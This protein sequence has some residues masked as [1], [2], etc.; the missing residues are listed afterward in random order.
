VA[1]A[2]VGVV[3]FAAVLRSRVGGEL[4][5]LYVDDLGT[6]MA[7]LAASVLWA[8]AGTRRSG[9]QRRFC[10]LLTA[11]CASWTLGEVI[12]AVYDLALRTA[13]PVPSWADLGYL[14]AI[15]F[16][17]AAL[18]SHPALAGDARRR[19]RFTLDGL[20]VAT[21][22]L[23]LSWTVVLGPL[24]H[25]TDLSTFGG[26]VTIAYPFSDVVVV[27]FVV[28]AVRRLPSE[29]RV[30]LWC[31]L[32]GLLALA[33]SDSIYAYQ[34]QAQDYQ[35]TGLLDTGWFAG[36]L[37][38]ALGAVSWQ[39]GQIATRA[40]DASP[41]FAALVVPFVPILAALV[42]IGLKPELVQQLDPV[43]LVI[44]FALVALVLL[45]QLLVVHDIVAAIGDYEGTLAARL[46]AVLGA[47]AADETEPLPRPSTR[48]AA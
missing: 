29:N 2:V 43:A 11:A 26:L 15:P 13:V 3:L 22:L 5:V 32:A 9:A 39:R 17:L 6:V 41:R 48:R 35:T 19:A 30:P 28:L 34:S 16:A 24:W 20:L 31:L 10:W 47:P 27:F 25:S 23:C 1:I 21:A 18:L 44:A 38:I 46:Q 4:F 8:R 40:V 36:Y 37:A 7:A 12:W 14:G 42:V 45:R 33:L